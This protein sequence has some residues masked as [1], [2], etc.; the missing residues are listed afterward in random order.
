MGTF[1]VK[2]AVAALDRPEERV[3]I[4]LLVDTGATYTWIPA[5][6]L[7]ALGVMAGRAQPVR[8]TDGRIIER[9]FTWILLTLDGRTEPTPCLI[10]DPGSEPLLGAVTLEI[11]GLGVD[12]LNRKLISVILPMAAADSLQRRHP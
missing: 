4:E 9:G 3:D 5:P 12:P 2:A 10:G 6:T 1:K 7:E 11:F 8:L